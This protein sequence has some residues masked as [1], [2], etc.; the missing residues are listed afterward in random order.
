MNEIDQGEL[1]AAGRSGAVLDGAA[2]GAKRAVPAALLRRCCHELKDQIDPR[3]L[4]LRGVAVAGC[5]DL[6]GLAVPFP[7]RF[8][9]CEFDSPLLVE[10]AELFELS[11]TGCPR[12]PGLLGNGLRLRRD[13]DL[14]RSR[15]AGAHWTSASTSKRAAVWLCES[16]I[17]SRLICLDATIDGRGDRAVQADR[18]AVG[19]AVR[20]IHRFTAAGEIRLI[21]AR[22]GG[23]VDITGARIESSD[24]PA[25]D[26][27]G[28]TV[29][30]NLFVIEDP[31]GRRPV[32]RGRFDLGSGRIAGRF[33]V[34]NATLEALAGGPAGSIYARSTATPTTISAERLSVG[35]DL[36]LAGRC[37]I[38][39]RIDLSMGDLSGMSVGGGCVLRSPGRTALDLTNAEIRGTFRLHRHAVVEGTIRLESAVI[40]GL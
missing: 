14:S 26:L 7:L 28:A 3:G 29:E 27:G 23:S 2:G 16:E 40:R 30:G 13:L 9:G 21:G 22:I 19:G 17:G 6:A 1:I 39:G 20:L 34:R 31:A 10:G 24:G 37:E 32:I 35:A 8:D 25:I 38:T 18:I 4:R 15:I 33:V 11:L 5:L 36:M 12:L